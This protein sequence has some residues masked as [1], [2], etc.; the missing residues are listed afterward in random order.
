MPMTA[1][2]I[3]VR[4]DR[5]RQLLPMTHKADR[6]VVTSTLH[7]MGPEALQDAIRQTKAKTEFE[8]ENDPYGEH[9]FGSFTLATGEKCFW[10]IDDY[11]G[12]DGIRC[13][14]TLMLAEDY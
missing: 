6:F 4:N 2:E 5:I 3:A 14:M 9:D 1:N 8:P 11:Q 13:V 7:A 10:K 12:T